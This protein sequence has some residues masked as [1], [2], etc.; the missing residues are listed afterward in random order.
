M[1]LLAGYACAQPA[2]GMSS[3][4]E[5]RDQD[6]L[7]HREDTTYVKQQ[8]QR[9]QQVNPTACRVLRVFALHVSPPTRR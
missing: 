8:Y 3:S 2:K 4:P 7:T 5:Q 1:P 6:G 9:E